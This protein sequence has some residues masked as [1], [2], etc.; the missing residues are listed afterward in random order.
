MKTNHVKEQLRAGKPSF[1]CWLSLPSVESARVIA[2]L[3]FDWVTVDAEHVALDVNTMGRI[4]GAIVDIGQAAPLV[5]LPVNSV[6]WYKWALDA[7]AWGVIVPMVNNR[8]EAERAVAWSRYPPAGQRSFGGTYSAYSFG[9]PDM[10]S[11][12]A[13]ANDQ[14]LVIPQIE[15]AAAL[16]NLEAILSTP[17]ID[18]AFVGP[19]DLH[20]QI[21]LPPSS[22]GAEPTFVEA[23]DRIKAVAAQNNLPL[24]I[25]CSNGSAAATRIREGFQMVSITTDLVSMSTAL[26]ENL[27]AA[28]D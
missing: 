1:G 13:E 12:A 25:F 5:R 2:R 23:L 22:E 17:G 11:Y 8:A 9:L 15:S 16:A 6:E 20:L 3:G 4:I 18:A 19:N 21:G 27:R 24:A 28:R 14:I 10:S 7:G 26:S